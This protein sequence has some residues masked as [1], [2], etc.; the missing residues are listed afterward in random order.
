MH[1][2]STVV[3]LRINLVHVNSNQQARV[4]IECF[5]MSFYRF[6]LYK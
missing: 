3:S 2:G 6:V 1:V 4:C 5:T